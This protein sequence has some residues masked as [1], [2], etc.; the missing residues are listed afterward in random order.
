VRTCWVHLGA[1]SAQ[2]TAEQGL[3][4][5]LHAT[6]GRYLQPTV[7]GIVLR[8]S[9]RYLAHFV[10][11]TAVLCLLSFE[12][13]LQSDTMTLAGRVP[14]SISSA[15][16]C[17]A[18]SLGP[19]SSAILVLNSQ[20]PLTRESRNRIEEEEEEE[21]NRLPVAWAEWSGRCWLRVHCRCAALLVLC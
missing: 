2:M 12:R 20:S 6:L 13:L 5:L 21:V 15:W 19:C 9:T 14:S 4:A 18:V 10:A 7:Y 17:S 11:R 16:T 1:R 3:V 8:Y